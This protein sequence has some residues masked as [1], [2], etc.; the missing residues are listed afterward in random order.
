M[1]DLKD[2]EILDGELIKYK[3]KDS[4]VVVPDGVTAIGGCAFDRCHRLMSV[5]IPEGVTRIG[6]WAFSGCYDL[7]YIKFPSSLKERRRNWL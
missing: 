4:D 3:G 6:R 7:A 5:T 1:S 2:F